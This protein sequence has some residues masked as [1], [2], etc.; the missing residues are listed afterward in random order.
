[1]EQ[2]FPMTAESKFPV[3]KTDEEWRRELTPEQYAVLRQ[4]ATEPRGMSP[5]NGEKRG[6]TFVCAG[7]GQPLFDSDTKY[8]SGSGWPSFFRPKEDA[9]DTTVD[10]SHF[11]VRTEVHCKRCGGHLGHVFE[12]G[13]APTGQRYCMNGTAL[14]FEPKE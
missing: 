1:M 2:R 3:Q 8:E 9:V 12:D 14:Q 4:H 5:L 13:P 6:G 11:M 7:C 10:G